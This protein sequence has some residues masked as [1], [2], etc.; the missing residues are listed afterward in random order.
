MDTSDHGLSHLFV[1]AGPVADGL[2]SIKNAL[3]KGFLILNCCSLHWVS[4]VPSYK[5]QRTEV[6]LYR[7]YYLR[8]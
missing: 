5:D 3:F 6:G 7:E 8:T 2:T 1:G 4:S